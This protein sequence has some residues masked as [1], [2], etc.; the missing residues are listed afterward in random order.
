MV[1]SLK[2]ETF[3]DATVV[4]GNTLQCLFLVLQEFPFLS[5]VYGQHVFRNNEQSVTRFLTKNLV[6]MLIAS[7]FHVHLTQKG[8][9]LSSHGG[10]LILLLFLFPLLV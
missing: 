1:S 3:T 7:S 6:P 4:S 9:L 5:S 10:D 8:S 2:L